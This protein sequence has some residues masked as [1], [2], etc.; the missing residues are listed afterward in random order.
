MDEGIASTNETFEFFYGERSN[1]EIR[2][3]ATGK[4]GHGSRMIDD[5]AAEKLES[6]IGKMLVLREEQKKFLQNGNLDLGDVTTINL[7][8]LKGGQASNVIPSELSATFDIRIPPRTK[9][10]YW[11]D[12]I[13]QICEQIGPGIGYTTEYFN[14]A[15]IMTDLS[16]DNLW[17]PAFKEACLELKITINPK[18]FQAVTD[19]RLLRNLG[20][21]TFGFSPMNNTP[22]LLHDNDEF[23][24]EKIF[25]RGIEIYEVILGKVIQLTD[26]PKP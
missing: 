10:S 17:W 24:N 3:T 9:V 21:P 19:A 11:E 2:V 12:K 22:I 18:I 7:T 1:W 25:L 20:I 26:K 5:T 15:T 4:A 6:F 16:S 13:N 8:M 14:D 23:L